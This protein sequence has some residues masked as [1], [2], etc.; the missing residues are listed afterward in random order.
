METF[1]R[2]GWP[3]SSVCYE[4]FSF[5]VRPPFSLYVCLCVCVLVIVTIRFQHMCFGVYVL[6]PLDELYAVHYYTL[7]DSVIRVNL[8][9]ELFSL[10]KHWQSWSFSIKKKKKEVFLFKK[11][12]QTCLYGCS[13][14][15]YNNRVLHMYKKTSVYSIKGWFVVVVG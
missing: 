13:R 2:F 9:E 3:S 11:K 10:L 1:V 14:M 6:R 12:T 7:L 15:R 4:K 8:H 5:F